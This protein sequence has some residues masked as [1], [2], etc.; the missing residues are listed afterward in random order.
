L[1]RG[2]TVL[3]LFARRAKWAQRLRRVF[4]RWLCHAGPTDSCAN[5]PIER[6]GT[7]PFL[8][9]PGRVDVGRAGGRKNPGSNLL[10]HA[11]NSPAAGEMN[12]AGTNRKRTRRPKPQTTAVRHSCLPAEQHS[13][14]FAE[15]A[16][17][18]RRAWLAAAAPRVGFPVS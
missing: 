3:R 12:K 1:V 5:P 16:L 8:V 10:R 18:L 2:E 13:R 11:A 17:V 6:S 4:A 14:Q 9:V 15:T 7:A